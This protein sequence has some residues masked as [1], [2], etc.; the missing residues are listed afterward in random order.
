MHDVV[1]AFIARQLTTVFGSSQRNDI[2]GL[3]L[4]HPKMKLKR[5]IKRLWSDIEHG[6]NLDLFV[7][8]ILAFVILFLNSIGVPLQPT[9][10]TAIILA[11]LGLITISLLISR[12]KLDDL[13]QKQADNQGIRF[14]VRKPQI[15][16]DNFVA[17]KEVWLLGIF[18]RGTTSENYHE[19]LQKVE[20]GGKIRTLIVNA[21]KVRMEE[22]ITRF[23]RGAIEEQFHADFHQTINR[24]KQFCQA[25][26]LPDNVQLKTIDFIPPFSLCI[27]P[28]TNDGGLIFVETYGYKSPKGSVPRYLIT[29][30]DQ[31]EWY[32]HFV[33]Q[34]ETMWQDAELVSL[35]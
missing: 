24:H 26:K 1:G 19:F 32:K 12:Y 9:Q 10:L 29:E 22:I 34:F 2:N 17:A 8:V 35:T 7:T 5:F 4:G 11:T 28:K 15:I 3:T 18:L 16:I 23:A 20:R 25:A 21:N 14:S 30:R 27:F 13:S 33:N 6:E 31:P